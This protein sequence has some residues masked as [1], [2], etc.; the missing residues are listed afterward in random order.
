VWLLAGTVRF[1]RTRF[2]MAGQRFTAEMA[3]MSLAHAGVAVFCFGVLMTEG[4]SLEKDVAARPG[5]SFQLRGYRFEF[6]GVERTTGPNYLAD[7]GTVRVHRGD[8][9]VSV[10]HPEKRAYASGGAI[11]TEAAIDPSPQRDLYV[12]LGEPLDDAGGWALRLYVKPFVRLI[13]LGAL[14]MAAG[15]FTVI[16]DSRFRRAAPA[17]RAP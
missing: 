4:L 14:L 16:G 9:E 12:A 3:G 5:Q 13:W 8:R 11:M 15:A 1:V 7:T 10:L 6:A 17:G 2:A